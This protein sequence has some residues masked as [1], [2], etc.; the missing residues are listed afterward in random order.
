MTDDATPPDSKLTRSKQRWASEH[1]FITG[2]APR[3][4]DARLPPGQHLVR[5]WPVLDLGR[6]PDIATER[7]ELRIG[8]LVARPL[9]LDWAGFMALP[10]SKA[11]SDMHCVTTWSRYD[12]DWAGVATHDLLEAVEPRE[13]AAFVLLHGY[14][15]YTTNVPLAD[16][17][18]DQAMIVHS[19]NGAPL[20]RSHGG[21]A[22]LL[23]PHL[24]LWKSAKWIRAIDFLG[25]DQAGFW[26][27]NGYHMRG[28]PWA[29]ERYS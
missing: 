15:G 25:A 21:P 27:R 4:G 19:W 13:A 10:Q 29:E 18:A 6:Q 9:V 11:R 5:D 22:R 7:W 24:Y 12:N 17:A 8:G 28:D 1:K 26:E 3:S 14:D 2:A 23:I 16:F 20:T